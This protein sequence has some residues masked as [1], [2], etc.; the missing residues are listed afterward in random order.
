MFGG[1][2]CVDKVDP[3]L[4]EQELFHGV[5]EETHMIVQIKTQ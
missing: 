3:L 5:T 2:Y 4:R 1:F